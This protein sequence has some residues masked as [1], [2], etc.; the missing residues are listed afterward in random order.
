MYR[1]LKLEVWMVSLELLRVERR[2]SYASAL[3]TAFIINLI[4]KA[5]IDKLNEVLKTFLDF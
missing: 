4:S 5:A 3:P 1:S 2:E